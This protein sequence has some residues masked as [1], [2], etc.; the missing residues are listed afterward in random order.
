M[1]SDS[2]GIVD[3]NLHET[4]TLVIRAPLEIGIDV[5]YDIFKLT[6]RDI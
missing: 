3:E 6:A 5:V 2:F 1:L 4:G